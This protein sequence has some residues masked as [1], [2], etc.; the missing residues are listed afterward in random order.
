MDKL[1]VS[2][3]FGSFGYV[4]QGGDIGSFVA[5][6]LDAK[7]ASCKGKYDVACLGRRF[8]A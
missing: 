4:C 3:G 1:M 2:P 6:I 8:I 7:H 5:R